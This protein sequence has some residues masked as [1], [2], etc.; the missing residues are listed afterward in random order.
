MDNINQNVISKPSGL[1]NV[2]SG[3]GIFI[4]GIPVSFIALMFTALSGTSVWTF[5]SSILIYGL[6]GYILGKI[7]PNL[8]WKS[9]LLLTL[10]CVFVVIAL[11]SMGRIIDFND[12][13]ARN[14]VLALLGITAIVSILSSHFG[15]RSQKSWQ[16]SISNIIFIIVVLVTIYGVG[17]FIIGDILSQQQIISSQ[18]QTL[19]QPAIPIDSKFDNRF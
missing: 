1:N 7:K 3:I 4:L 18:Q 15:S 14:L 6:V 10:G 19:T 9:G 12:S 16:G 13:V 11:A 5:I 8:K 2:L 17:S